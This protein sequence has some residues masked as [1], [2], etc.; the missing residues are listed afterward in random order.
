MDRMWWNLFLM[1]LMTIGHTEWQVMLVNRLHAGRISCSSLRRIRHIHDAMIPLFP[2]FLLWFLGFRGPGL[3]VGG[4][5]GDAN[6]AWR[7][8]LVFCLLGVLGLIF[9]SLRWHW[10]RLPA[11][12]R[13]NHSQIIDLEKRCEQPLVGNGP[14]RYLTRFPGNEIFQVEFA[15]KEFELPRL[16]PEWDGLSILHLTDLH[17]QGTTALPF[18]EEVI[19]ITKETPADL[20]VMTGDLL[21]DQSKVDWLPSTLGQLN[22]RLGCYY[23]LGNHDWFLK[24]KEIRQV[25]TELGWIDVAGRMIEIPARKIRAALR[26]E[27]HSPANQPSNNAPLVIGGSERPWMGG[28]PPFAASDENA[29]R[30]F[31]SHSPDNIGWAKQKNVDLMLSGHN[32]GGQVVLP[33]IGPVYSP[34]QFGVR[35]A[36]GLFWE[37]PTL[38]YVSRGLSSRHPLRLGCHPEVTRITLRSRKP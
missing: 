14:F 12:Q 18:F 11:L 25:M 35:Y 17:M 5:W 9:S 2:L 30:L 7:I 16:P 13:Q 27:H 8:L 6:P 15:E 29:F 34:S 37:P 26:E 19:R 20:V 1:G 32:H 28:Q 4:T 22:A 23:I 31:L 36:S 38:M 33:L 10:Y 21:D 3:L 24:P